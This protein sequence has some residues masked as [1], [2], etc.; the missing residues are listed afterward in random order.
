ML[1]DYL[2]FFK[3]LEDSGTR[4]ISKS[5]LREHGMVP[6]ENAL[7]GLNVEKVHLSLDIDI[8]SLLPVY[9]CRF[10]NTVGL[11]FDEI[12]D[13][14]QSLHN[15]FSNGLKLVGFDLM[16]VDIH[17]LGARIDSSHV[18]KTDEVGKLFLE[19]VGGVV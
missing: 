11:S 9:A 16:E 19:F 7:Q 18:D 10:L 1:S 13:I 2:D 8:G 17:K 4:F 3:S 15:S 14:F 5:N 12:R 6:L